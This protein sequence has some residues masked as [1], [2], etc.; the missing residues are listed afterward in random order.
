M[1]EAEGYIRAQIKY[2]AK[3]APRKTGD[4]CRK[5]NLFNKNVVKWCHL[6]TLSMEE[7]NAWK[8]RLKNSGIRKHPQEP[9]R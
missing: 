8:E 6:I 2:N 5:N 4:K 7:K 3:T 1:E 9:M